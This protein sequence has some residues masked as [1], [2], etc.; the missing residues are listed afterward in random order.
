MDINTSH[1]TSYL[2]FCV[3]AKKTAIQLTLPPKKQLYSSHSLSH[4]PVALYSYTA[5]AY[6]AGL[7]RIQYTAYTL[8]SPIRRPSG[9]PAALAN[10]PDLLVAR[11]AVVSGQSMRACRSLCPGVLGRRAG[12]AVGYRHRKF[13]VVSTDTRNVST[14]SWHVD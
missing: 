10:R 1:R 7:Y 9:P 12:G 2:A 6:T 11:R 4:G 8:Y 3:T 14:A 13:L 5:R